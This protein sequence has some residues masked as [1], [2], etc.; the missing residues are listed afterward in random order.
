M[1]WGWRF[2]QSPFHIDKAAR[3]EIV[4]GPDERFGHRQSG[5][6]FH[7]LFIDHFLERGFDY[8]ISELGH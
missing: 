7:L 5:E 2:I 1:F 6:R 8:R 4:D 3:L